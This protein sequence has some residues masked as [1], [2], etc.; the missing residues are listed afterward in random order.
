MKSRAVLVAVIRWMF[1]R[2]RARNL[3]SVLFI[4]FAFIV[5]IIFFVIIDQL[6]SSTSVPQ[7]ADVDIQVI[8]I[9]EHHEGK[10]Q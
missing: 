1:T 7:L 8:I 6:T 3:L 10:T 4:V 5:L 2:R 9:E